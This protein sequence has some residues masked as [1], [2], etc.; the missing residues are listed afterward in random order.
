MM[1]CLKYTMVVLSFAAAL[2]M[3]EGKV[4]YAQTNPLE[5]VA[6]SAAEILGVDNSLLVKTGLTQALEAGRIDNYK[7]QDTP[8]MKAFYEARDYEPIWL[9]NSFLR[10]RK[11]EALVKVFEESWKHGLNP[12]NY[13]LSELRRLMEETKGS[14]RYKLDLMLSDALVRYGRDM[15]G[16]RVNPRSIG[17]R[18]KYW[19][20]P[21]R[22]IDILDHVASASDTKQGLK[23]LMPQGKLYKKLQAELVRL[24]KTTPPE[25]ETKPLRLNG[26]LRPGNNHK[27][28]LKIRD[29]MG[30]QPESAP[31]GA[32]YYDDQLAEAVMSFQKAHGLK[33]DAIIGSHTLQLMNMTREDRINQILAN[34]ERLRWVEPNKPE[35]YIMV[36][37]P[38]AML[39]AVQDG[40]VKLEMPVVVGR[41]KRPTNIF[42][43]QITGIRFNPTWTVP[44]TIKKEDYLPK[45]Q[46]DPYY[47]SDRGIELMD[48]DMSVDPGLIEWNE[49]SWQEA[50]AM[51]FVQGSGRNNPLGLVRFI[52]NNPFNIYLHDTPKR[53]YFKLS[54]RALSSGC[55][56]LSKAQELADFV[57]E[58][59]DDWSE[60][61]KQRI[62]AKGKQTGVLAQHPLPVYILYQ[63]VWLGDREQIV[64]GPDLYGHD[65]KLLKALKNING[66]VYPVKPEPTQTAQNDVSV[67]NP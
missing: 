13:H 64:Y 23:G 54:N 55:I 30:F 34:L 17:Q 22:G 42:S 67:V 18:S 2:G 25:T 32:Y 27:M 4:A 61:K 3:V 37:V 66:F 26:L 7:F 57:L 41:E 43:T 29:R 63:T 28:V 65:D 10:Q 45:L 35:R 33:P 24:Y 15:T 36:N 19:R 40:R 46:E 5:S 12:E 8:G 31:Q 39:W 9:Q 38:A 58:A 21:L 47:L 44:P 56:R 49:V 11:A 6:Q 20:Q 59:N 48:G 16:M 62:L 1:L 50:N 14:E 51:R 53:S 52:M 60:E